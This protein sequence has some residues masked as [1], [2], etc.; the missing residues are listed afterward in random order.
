MNSWDDL[1]FWESDDYKK[2][3]DF[4]MEEDLKDKKVFPYP[5]VRRQAFELTPFDKVKVVIL[6]QDPY[7]TK[8]MA[9]GLAFSVQP[10]VKPWPPSLRNILNEAVEDA[11]IE[12]PKTGNLEPWAKKGVLLLNTILTVEE[13]KPLSHKGIGWEKLTYEALSCLSNEREGIVWMLW[14]REAQQ[15]EALI[16]KS[17]H[18][19]ITSSHPS[20]LSYRK[21]F[22]GHKPFTR[23]NALLKEMGKDEI[24]WRL[25]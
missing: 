24:N 12:L 6:G 10:H 2:I 25:P 14:G 21:G 11:H 23:C 18:R 7:H 5:N 13:G 19:V 16:D 3:I 8:G 20:P 1:K 17:K 22:M 15:Y 4:L 9:H